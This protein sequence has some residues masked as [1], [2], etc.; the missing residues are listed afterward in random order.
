M[1]YRHVCDRC[2]RDI[3]GENFYYRVVVESPEDRLNHT[4]IDRMSFNKEYCLKCFEQLKDFA[5]SP[6]ASVSYNT[7]GAR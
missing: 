5:T 1:A 7:P 3:V 2:G 6:Y 4:T